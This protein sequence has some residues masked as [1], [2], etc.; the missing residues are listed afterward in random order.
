[1]W[2]NA[3]HHTA[4]EWF[5]E[6][7]LQFVADPTKLEWLMLSMRRQWGGGGG[8]GNAL[9]E[10]NS[11]FMFFFFYSAERHPHLINDKWPYVCSLWSA[12]AIMLWRQSLIGRKRSIL[13][14]N[15][16]IFHVRLFFFFVPSVFHFVLHS[17][18]PLQLWLST[19]ARP[20]EQSSFE[21]WQA[22][23]GFYSIL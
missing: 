1:M 12:V 2:V 16:T 5:A 20:V 8:G 15:E 19:M 23:N 22:P 3:H 14:S 7:G 18:W 13:I 9:P 4:S 21:R 6:T 17:G 10:L 11:F